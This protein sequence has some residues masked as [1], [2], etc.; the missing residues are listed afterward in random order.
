VLSPSQFIATY[1]E[2]AD[3]EPLPLAMIHRDL[4][5]HMS[6]SAALN[7]QQLRGLMAVFR[8]D[9]LLLVA[10]GECR[11]NRVRPDEQERHGYQDTEF[12]RA[13]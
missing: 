8:I 3:G 6:H 1:L 2:P 12:T 5:L 7:R 4:A 11:R 13:V 9:A 10:E